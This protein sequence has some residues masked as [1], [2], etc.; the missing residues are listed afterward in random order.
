MKW[1]KKI[2]IQNK[3]EITHS[4]IVSIAITFAFSIWYFLK[5]S[6]FEWRPINPIS[7][8]SL[9]VREF[10]SALVFV[11]IGAFLYYVVKL[12]KIL[13][14]VIVEIMGSR[15]LYKFVK[16][17]IW[18]FLILTMY[19]YIVP[20]V[21]DFLNGTISVVYNISI[22]LL[23]LFPPVVLFVTIFSLICLITIRSDN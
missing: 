22:L 7:Q 11:T 4:A 18:I 12:W 1:H 16:S 15:E 13:Y 19:F 20:R 2:L 5:G 8:P 3:K 10:Y 9:L 6:T 17:L 21:V 14:F 23:Y